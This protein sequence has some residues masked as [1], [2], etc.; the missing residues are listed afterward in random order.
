[1][2]FY[3]QDEK[4]KI[5]EFCKDIFSKLLNFDEIEIPHDKIFK[6]LRGVKISIFLKEQKFEEIIFPQEN[7]LGE[8]MIKAIEKIIKKSKMME[9]DLQDLQFNVLILT[10]PS[11]I[12]DN[13]EKNFDLGKDGLVIEFMGYKGFLFPSQDYKDRIEFLEKLCKNAGL[14]KDSW[15]N[16]RVGFSVFRVVD[17]DR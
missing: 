16:S 8:N 7:S 2:V 6:E 11:K 4:E 3:K 13:I 5:M 12:L 1:M 15:Q 10:N 9:K 17:L 14:T